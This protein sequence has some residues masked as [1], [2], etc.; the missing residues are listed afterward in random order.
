[1][2]ITSIEL[3]VDEQCYRAQYEI[4]DLVDGWFTLTIWYQGQSITER[5]PMYSVNPVN[6]VLQPHGP[7]LLQILLCS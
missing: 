6:D 5:V 7:R 1:L 2:A 4:S 3:V